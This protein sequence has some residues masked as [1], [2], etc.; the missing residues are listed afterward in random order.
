M[1]SSTVLERLRADFDSVLASKANMAHN[2]GTLRASSPAQPLTHK[3]ATARSMRRSSL[4]LGSVRAASTEGVGRRGCLRHTA[5]SAAMPRRQSLP[6]TGVNK[7]RFAR[8]CALARIEKQTVSKRRV[9]PVVER[10]LASSRSAAISNG[11]T[12]AETVVLKDRGITTMFGMEQLGELR[13]LDLSFNTLTEVECWQPNQLWELCL[14]NNQLSCLK[15]VAGFSQL[16]VRSLVVSIGGCAYAARAGCPG[17]LFDASE[18]LRRQVVVACVLQ[19]WLAQTF[20]N[21]RSL[22][23]PQIG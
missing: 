2:P 18:L 22:T 11:S 9:D 19:T 23:C 4:P 3:L 21:C 12:A 8:A 14:G 6:S 7:A 20:S 16:Q 13:K 15:G 10:A 17:Y 5:D 1:G